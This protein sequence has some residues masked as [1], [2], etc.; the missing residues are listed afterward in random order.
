MKRR[1]FRLKNE[2]TNER[3]NKQ[4]NTL[5]PWSRVFPEKLT[6]PQLVKKFPA[7][8]WTRR[9]ITAF[10]TAATCTYPVP[11][12]PP[13]HAP[14]PPIILLVEDQ[15]Y[16]NITPWQMFY[17][18]RLLPWRP[19]SLKRLSLACRTWKSKKSRSSETS[20]SVYQA[21]WCSIPGDWI[22]DIGLFMSPRFYV[23][24]RKRLPEWVECSAVHSQTLQRFRSFGV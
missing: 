17:S 21:T 24:G 13:V 11:D 2:R 20:V 6:G 15:N 1:D 8:H 19:H 7:S 9:F 12:R 3:T 5:T 4:T 23:S 16:W 18:Y 22:S 10:T 14:P